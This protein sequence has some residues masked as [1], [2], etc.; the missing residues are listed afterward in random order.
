MAK[1]EDQAVY[2]VAGKKNVRENKKKSRGL[3][4]PGDSEVEKIIIF[5]QNGRFKSYQPE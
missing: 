3:V 2:S 5:Y 4:N 1:S